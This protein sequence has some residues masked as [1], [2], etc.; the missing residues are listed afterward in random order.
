MTVTIT[1]V[2]VTNTAGVGDDKNDDNNNNKKNE[3][4]PSASTVARQHDKA[5]EAE[6]REQR[7]ALRKAE[8]GESHKVEQVAEKLDKKV[9]CA[10]VCVC[11]CVCECV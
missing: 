1:S 2:T 4:R 3:N 10:C 6:K 11:V 9:K 7:E 8:T 5:I